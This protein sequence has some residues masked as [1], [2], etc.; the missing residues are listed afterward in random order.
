MSAIIE[1]RVALLLDSNAGQILKGRKVGL[2]KESLRVGRD[3]RISQNPHP[4]GLGSALTHPSITTDYSEALIEFVTPPFEHFSETLQFL[5]DAHQFV[6]TQLDDEILWA[7][8]MPCVV[9]GD[10]SIRLAEYGSSN[11][12]IMK[13][14][15]RRGLGNRY[16]RVMQVIAGV[17]FNY[18]YPG[19]FWK[20]YQSILG[21]KRD[22]QT[23]ISESYLGMVR[24]LLRYGWLVPYLFGAAP[25]I[26]GSFLGS[27]KTSLQRLFKHSYYGPFATS[28]RVGDIGY[29]NNKEGKAGIMVNY[30]SLQAYIDSLRHAISTPCAAYQTIGLK[31]N[32]QWQQLNSNILQIE[33]EHYSSV[34]PKQI[35]LGLEK[36][37]S[38]LARRGVGY[39]ELRSL[40]VNP[41]EPIGINEEHMRFLESFLLFSL[42]S[43]SPPFSVHEQIDINQNLNAVAYRG[44]D[45]AL[46]LKQSGKDILLRDWAR[47]IFDDM[48]ISCD[49]LDVGYR[50]PIY[51]SALQQQ[52][53]KNDD[54]S[55]TPSAKMLA[56]MI[57]RGE[58][59]YDFSLRMSKQHQQWFAGRALDAEKRDG[60]EAEAVKSIIAQ[61]N[62]EGSDDMP[63]DVFLQN[64]MAQD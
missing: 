8:S 50:S 57:D 6:Y 18:S 45:P 24:N 59:F 26:C 16:G 9:D 12:A 29:Q 63:F 47:E 25:A 52:R 32:G 33:N 27:Q 64:Y 4:A 40:D 22:S 38:A 62:I 1:K 61:K 51:C 43:P 46:R 14:V 56:D 3:G 37:S 44:R 15:Y 28:L 34:R 60:F 49:L 10:A 17:H 41:Y 31:S 54:S 30:N 58:E 23:F 42:L 7:T 13:T 53:D 5:D 2:E 55:L 48:A 19:R 20:I 21:D 35:P 39:V 11:Q 36:P